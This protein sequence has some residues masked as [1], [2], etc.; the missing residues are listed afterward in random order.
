MVSLA[1]L[2][3]SDTYDGGVSPVLLGLVSNE[4]FVASGGAL[5]ISMSLLLNVVVF[6]RCLLI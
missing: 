4:P 6:K 2:P 5:V 3:Q 1:R